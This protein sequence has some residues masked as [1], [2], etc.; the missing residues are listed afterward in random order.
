MRS[1][2]C[3]VATCLV[4]SHMNSIDP[5]TPCGPA[6]EGIDNPRH[7]DRAPAKDAAV[8]RYRL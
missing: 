3:C 1:L 8:A 7:L 2:N 6:G 5:T 4:L